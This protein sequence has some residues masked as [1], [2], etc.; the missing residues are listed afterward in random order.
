MTENWYRIS[1]V[2][3][4]ET[5]TG[6]FLDTSYEHPH[7][8]IDVVQQGKL[9]SALPGPS[10]AEKRRYRN[11]ANYYELVSGCGVGDFN[12]GWLNRALSVSYTVSGTWSTTGRS[13]QCTQS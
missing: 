11:M 13:G 9:S 2:T 7:A 1:H 12:L 5:L 4:N 3:L 6:H 10:A 8:T